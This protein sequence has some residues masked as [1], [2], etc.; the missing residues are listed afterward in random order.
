MTPER[1]RELRDLLAYANSADHTRAVIGLQRALAILD[2]A[3]AEQHPTPIPMLLWCPR[4]H[5]Q[6]VDA[7]SEGWDN[8]PHRSHLCHAC[9][10]VWRPADVE[11]TGVAAIGTRGSRDTWSIAEHRTAD[12]AKPPRPC[13][14][15]DAAQTPYA[16]VCSRCGKPLVNDVSPGSLEFSPLHSTTEIAGTRAQGP[17]NVVVE[18]HGGFDGPLGRLLRDSS[19]RAAAPE[20]LGKLRVGC[21]ATPTESTLPSVVRPKW[22]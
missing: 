2:A 9:G 21:H 18:I 20:N 22:R 15:C 6:H 5:A 8:P 14:W 3:I 16:A 1:M 12:V 4:C 7:P 19:R 11:T 17:L 10:C 13:P